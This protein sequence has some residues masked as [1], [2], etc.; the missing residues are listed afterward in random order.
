MSQLNDE[1][2]N[3][4]GERISLDLAEKGTYG[5]INQNSSSR[6]DS[7]RPCSMSEW[8]SYDHAATAGWSLSKSILHDG[9]NDW[10][11]QS[12]AS[13]GNICEIFNS[14]G[15]IIVAF[16]CTGTTSSSNQYIANGAWGGGNNWLILARDFSGS[17]FQIRFRHD[18]SGN[19]YTSEPHASSGQRLFGTNKWYFVC[20]TYDNGATSN[21]ATWYY[22]DY[23]GTSLTTVTSPVEITTPTGTKNTNVAQYPALSGGK[24]AVTRPFKGNITLVGG[25]SDILTSGEVTTL[26]NSGA[27]YQFS[28]HSNN[29]L[30]FHDMASLSGS[31]ITPE[32][33]GS[34]YRIVM[35][36]GASQSTTI[37]A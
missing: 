11:R 5:D 32:T 8:Y 35:T 26:W 34:G 24:G 22:G 18:F 7:A 33:G 21:N 3:G 20:L 9:V 14:G 4:Q 19:N 16:K 36:D 28:N 23:S 6:P 15:T 31:T 13:Y 12:G 25:W 1:L 17:D 37:P 27:P 2:S 10:S 30:Y 29:L